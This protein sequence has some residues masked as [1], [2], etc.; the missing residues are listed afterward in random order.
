MTSGRVANLVIAGVPKAGTGSLFAYLAQHPQICPSDVKETGYFN[1]YHPRWYPGPPPSVE[2]Y[3]AHWAGCAGERYAM[4]ATP[5]YCYAGKPVITAMREVLGEPKIVITLRDPVERLWSAYTFQHAVGN[6]ARIGSFAEYLDV[7]ERRARD[8]GDL[9]PGDGLHG[10]YIGYYGDYLPLWLD[11]FGDDLRVVFV[12][13]MRS[14]PH[15]VVSGLCAWLDLETDVVAD[16]D[17]DVRNAT[18]HP[19]SRY[20]AAAAR[21]LKRNSERLKLLPPALERRVK[22]A[23]SRLNTGDLTE[24]FDPALR[25][26]VEDLY[27]DSTRKTAQALRAYG[28][29]ELPSWLHPDPAAA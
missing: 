27:R 20:L 18:R 23:Y 19:R 15:A 13:D 5:S 9:V 4:E 22:R 21:T 6:N 7:L 8:G 2:S 29:T 25:R 17:F 24:S 16:F 28:Y 10:L 11:E 3:A 26:R 12:D 1:R 14:D